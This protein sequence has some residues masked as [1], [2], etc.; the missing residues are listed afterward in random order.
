MPDYR[1]RATFYAQ[2]Y[3]I[4]PRIFGRQIQQES[5]FNPTVR[6]S[7]GAVGIAQIVP[8]W[9]PG[10]DPLD[11]EAALDYAARWM[12]QLLKKYGNYKDAL[13]VYNSGQPW[14]VGQTYGETSH[15]VSTILGGGKKISGGGTGAAPPA[16]A[17][18]AADLQPSPDLTA[19]ATMSGLGALAAG[20][21]SPNKALA[22]LFELD[23][24]SPPLPA[25]G[26]KAVIPGISSS[27]TG[28][29]QE[30]VGKIEQRTGPSA[31]HNVAIL[32]F[33]GKVGQLAGTVLT[34][35]G[36]QSHS[37]TTTTGNRSA[38]ADGNAA[39]IPASGAELIR[40]G[41]TALIAAGMPAA[42]ARKQTGGLFNVN[43]YQ[44]IF[45][46]DVGGNHHDHLHVGVRRG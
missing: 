3:G 10:V 12:S 21:Y 38:H 31:P 2:R 41:R 20:D 33:V 1:A 23:A 16:P 22:E 9:H 34:P 45:N 5:G 39:D 40:L 28:G 44:V 6:S 35:W 25:P 37:L 36:N 8:K 42:K 4:D 43:G 17:L 46:T 18:P 32:R 15:Y 27:T 11:P 29:W 19:Q 13:S 26:K 7:A 30:W 14:K 24:V